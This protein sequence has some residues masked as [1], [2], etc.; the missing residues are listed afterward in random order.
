MTKKHLKEP[1]N[2]MQKTEQELQKQIDHADDLQ[3]L[4][5]FRPIDDTFMRVLFRNDLPLTELVL[6]TV[7]G[8]KDLH[9]N[10]QETQK[11]LI[12]LVGARG[13]A[14]DVYGT[15]GQ[16]RHYDLEIQRS[17]SG[18]IPERARYHASALDVENLNTGQLFESL[19]T[20][21]IIFIAENDIFNA[22]SAVYP[23]ER[24]NMKTNKPFNDRLHILYANASYI[25]D[26]PVGRLMHDFLCSDPDEM[27]TPLLAEKT[28]YY[29]TDPKGVE[30]M[31]KIMDELR[32]EAYQRGH[33]Q[34]LEQGMEQGIDNTRMESIKSIMEKLHYSGSQAMDVLSIP[35][36]ERD[37]YLNRIS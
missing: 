3:R 32:Q 24:I 1:P 2:P 10:T 18:A 37:R 29:K 36:A 33:V 26:D 34:G 30:V 20:T 28:R 7:T 5:K 8:M 35:P 13:L 25:G 12:R 23:V 11:D 31:C 9:L 17:D 27:L 6:E 4:R 14:L 15:D 21:Y 19:P 16:D 22:G